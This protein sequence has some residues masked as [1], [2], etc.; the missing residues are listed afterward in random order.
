MDRTGKP[1]LIYDPNTTASDGAGGF[2]RSPFP[3]NIIPQSRF[4]TVSAKILPLI[5]S[6]INSGILNNFLSLGAN[7]FTRDQIDLKMDHSFTDRHRIN[8]FLYVGT[9]DQVSAPTLPGPLTAA[10]DTQ[11]HSRWARLA[12]DYVISPTIVNHATLGFTREGQFWRSLSADQ[13]WPTQLGLTGVNTGAGNTFPFV[14]FNDG[15]STWDNTN[16]TKTVG[17][18]VNNAWQF[19]ESLS[20]LRGAHSLKF[21]A[22]LRWLQT[23]GADFFG[24]QGN[25]AFSTFETALPTAAGRSSSGSAFASFLLGAVDQGQLNVHQYVPSNRYD[26]ASGFVQD[27]WKVS[28]KLTVNLGMRYEIYFPHAEARGNLGGF[29]PSVPNPGAGGRP[30]AIAFLGS[31][32][33]RSGRTSFADTYYKNFGPRIGFAFTA[34]AKTVVRGGFG[35]YY[36][37]GNADAGLRGSQSYGYGFNASPVFATPNTGVTPAFNWDN[38][39]PQNFAKPPLIDPTVANNSTVNMIGRG[40]GRPPYFQNWSF[41]VQRELLKNLLLEANYVGVKGTRLGNGL[42]RPNELNPQYLS[43]GS[44]LTSAASSPQAQA[45]GIALPY[46]GFTGSVAQALRPF[47]QYL[48][49]T[50]NTNPNGNSTYNAL[51]VKVEKRLSAGFTGILSYAWS[52]TISD[53]DI[54]AGGGP[55][56]QTFYNRSLE[57]AVADIDVPQAVALSFLYELP[58]GPGKHFLNHGGAVGKIVGG[59]EFT[60]IQQYS[61]ATPIVLTATNTLPL[62]NSTLRPNAVAGVSQEASYTSFNPAVNRYINPAAFAVPGPFTF[63]SS[64]RSYDGLRGPFNFNEN[65]GMLKRTTITE[66]VRLEFR[67]EFFNVFNRVVLGAPAANI[68]Q[69]SFGLISSQ[70][71]TPRQG[72]MAL[73]LIF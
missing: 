30:G 42:I 27:D 41:G 43:L 40:D 52:K 21:G 56:G 5:P 1:E 51:Q 60:A 65:W 9:Q 23:N 16:G 4:S 57:K 69:A 63:G 8:G 10:L 36:A 18:Q 64:A 22:D 39:F 68:S 33:G 28:R 14:S 46:A 15:Y 72:Q 70:A 25:F 24:S 6:P 7:T 29:D 48:D 54:Q 55:G 31:G 61:S 45:A 20:W 34:D 38:G 13:G 12:D 67:A 49:I 50:N 11:Y 2:T 26:Y 17:S 73:K 19:N 35:V 59:W 58:V 37:P 3:G 62:F 44:L 53:G 66:K 32:P 47:P 71:N